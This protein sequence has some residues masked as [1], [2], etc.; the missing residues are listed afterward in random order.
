MRR[1]FLLTMLV[2]MLLSHSVF[3]NAQH[4]TESGHD[5]DGGKADSE[6][7][8]PLFGKI[9][10]TINGGGY[11]YMLLESNGK[12]LWVAVR[13]MKVEVGQDI[14]LHPGFEMNNFSSKA[15]NRTFDSILFSDGP[16][17]KGQNKSPHPGMP[18]AYSEDNQPKD[19][20]GSKGSV[21]SQIEG[22]KVEKATGTNAYTVMELYEKR[23]ELNNKDIALKGKVVKV[24][25]AIL[26]KNW[27]HIQDGSGYSQNGT[28]DIVVTTSEE[29]AVGEVVTINGVLYANK[30]F[31]SG[32]KYDV[33]IENAKLT[34]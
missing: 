34:K 15:L 10:E 1:L 9:L 14:A 3:V 11:T 5:H 7:E 13:E 23:T 22:V 17:S 16:I 30:D 21:P 25:S 27:L 29:A 12:K 24:S 19:T 18:N 4:A 6:P 20:V 31:G 8:I 26:G 28:H 33:I 32:Y 2:A